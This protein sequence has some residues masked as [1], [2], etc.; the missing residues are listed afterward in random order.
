[1]Q[2][3]GWAL[4]GAD[5]GLFT[6]GRLALPRPGEAPLHWLHCHPLPAPRVL[7]STVNKWPAQLRLPS[8]HGHRWVERWTKAS[9]SPAPTEPGKGGPGRPTCSK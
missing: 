3:P 2:G 7:Y 8:V 5:L 1:M 9:G 6:R 4:L